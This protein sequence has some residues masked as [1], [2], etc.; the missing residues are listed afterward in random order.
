[1]KLF[2]VKI[3]WFDL[4]MLMLQ[5]S[6]ILEIKIIQF[7]IFISD[8]LRTPSLLPYTIGTPNYALYRQN[9]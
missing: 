1:M 7:E 9:G 5:P 6:V 2:E 3:D 8:Q 4:G